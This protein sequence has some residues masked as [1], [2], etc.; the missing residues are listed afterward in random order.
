M[1]E[2]KE[3]GNYI[4]VPIKRKYHCKAILNILN[5]GF[6]MTDVELDVLNTMITND[7]K[8]LTKETR[9]QLLLL[10]NKEKYTVNNHIMKLKSKGVLINNWHNR[11]E[12]APNIILAVE[13]TIKS[14]ILTFELCPQ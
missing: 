7:I 6:R 5:F 13:D 4:K 8:I 9:A 12:I 11:L 1:E 14:G 2:V 10:L 3:A